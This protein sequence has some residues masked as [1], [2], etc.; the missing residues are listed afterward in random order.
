MLTVAAGSSLAYASGYMKSRT[1]PAFA[2]KRPE[3]ADH[4]LF[5]AVASEKI[6]NAI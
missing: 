4:T 1:Q 2:A 5:V 3:G 6:V